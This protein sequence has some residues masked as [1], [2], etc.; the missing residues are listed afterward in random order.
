MKSL[1]SVVLPV[2]NGEMYVAT[3]IASVIA[4][5]YPRWELLIV[6]DGST[7]TTADVVAR[8]VDRRIV[9]IR[10]ENRGLSAA[11]NAGISRA[12]GE[13][14]AFLDHDDLWAPQFLTRCVSAMEGNLHPRLGAVYTSALYVDEGGNVLPQ[15]ASN[16]VSTPLLHDRLLEGGFFPVHAVL[17]RTEAVIALGVFDPSLKSVE[18]WDLWL[19]LSESHGVLAIPESLAQYRVR[20]G[21]M[22][23]NQARM[24]AARMA[25]L[26]KHVGPP[27]DHWSTWPDRKRK[28]YA[29]AYRAAALDWIEA[30]QVQQ[31]EPLL[32]RAVA[33]WP[34]LLGRLDTFYTLACWDQPRG[35]R[36]QAQRLDIGRNG[37]KVLSLLDAVLGAGAEDARSLA[38]WRSIAY[39]NAYLALGML[40]DQA[41]AW[42]ASRDY[43]W[44]AVNANPRLLVSPSVSQRLVKVCAVPAIMPRLRHLR[45]S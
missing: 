20:P 33:M 9:Y 37:A 1:V 4:Q 3:T 28:A 42:E 34:S 26:A 19:R 17:A 36:G 39:G 43:L 11:R 31:A 44:R 24:H 27:T 25:V 35:Y 10:Q 15:A 14:V 8:F 38:R 2:Y 12:E 23:T 16:V 41:K 40:C 22:S 6:D 21:S 32:A 30:D 13:Y 18:D 5:T 29:F 45:S 7:D